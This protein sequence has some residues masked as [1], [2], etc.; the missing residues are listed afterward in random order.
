MAQKQRNTGLFSNRASRSDWS[1]HDELNS[2]FGKARGKSEHTRGK[3]LASSSGNKQTANSTRK[4]NRGKQ[5][6]ALIG[7]SMH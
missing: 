6:S 2:I 1:D 5:R 7:S 4:G 3:G